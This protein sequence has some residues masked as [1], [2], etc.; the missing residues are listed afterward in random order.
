MFVGDGNGPVE[1][2][3]RLAV[4]PEPTILR[5]AGG[6]SALSVESPTSLQDQGGLGRNER[7]SW[8]RIGGGK[9]LATNHLVSEVARHHPARGVGAFGFDSCRL[10]QRLT[11]ASA[12][13]ERRS[14]GRSAS[15]SGLALPAPLPPPSIRVLADNGPQESCQGHSSLGAIWGFATAKDRNQRIGRIRKRR[16]SFRISARSG[17]DSQALPPSCQS[18]RTAGCGE[19]QP[20]N[21]QEELKP[22]VPRESC[23]T[24]PP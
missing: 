5:V 15:A 1:R 3:H 21:P 11:N 7:N 17:F 6:V 10:H 19:W 16:K 22:A 2:R 8:G 12:L 14:S 9:Q 18:D 20:L 4:V 13:V 23:G 24:T